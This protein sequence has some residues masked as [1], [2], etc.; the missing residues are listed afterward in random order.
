MFNIYL[1]TFFSDCLINLF[2]SII[3]HPIVNNQPYFIFYPLS[4]LHGRGRAG[5][6]KSLFFILSS[7]S[8]LCHWF[9]WELN[10]AHGNKSFS[11]SLAVHLSL[12]QIFQRSCKHVC[13]LKN[14]L[15]ALKSNTKTV[16][17][18]SAFHWEIKGLI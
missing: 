9:Q 3:I 16:I 8:E 18:V 6:V 4:I 7:R 13:Q 5:K 12:T 15:W 10:Q 1:H 14:Q 2:D 17:P 11:L